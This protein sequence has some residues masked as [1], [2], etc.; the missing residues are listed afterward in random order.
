MWF[1]WPWML[2]EHFRYT[3]GAVL[4]INFAVALVFKLTKGGGDN[5]S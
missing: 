5:M 3:A 1:Y 4:G 2:S